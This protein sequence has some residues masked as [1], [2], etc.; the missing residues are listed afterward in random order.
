MTTSY[1][2]PDSLFLE[3]TSSV[4]YATQ[5]MAANGTTTLAFP[6]DYDG[7]ITVG[8]V[9]CPTDTYSATANPAAMEGTVRLPSIGQEV[10]SF[11]ARVTSTG[12]RSRAP[13]N[14]AMDGATS[15]GS[16]STRKTEHG[17]SGRP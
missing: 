11:T 9:Q 8:A 13:S 1:E 14:P 3:V 5:P 4:G 16:F 10:P 12:R 6:V 17:A 7:G 2:G 15:S